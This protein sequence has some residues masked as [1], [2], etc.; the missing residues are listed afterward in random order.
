MM[1]A[2]LSRRAWLSGLSAAAVSHAVP[3]T[4]LSFCSDAPGTPAGN[5][6]F[7]TPLGDISPRVLWGASIGSPA[8][9]DPALVQAL[10]MEKPRV[11]AIANALKFGGPPPGAP[12]PADRWRECD[13]IVSLAMRIG[14]GIRGDALAW[15][16]WLPEWVKTLA[17]QRPTGWRDT[18]RDAFDTHFK[19]VFAHF[20]DLR[21]TL[22][23][24]PL[25]WCGVVNEPFNP[26]AARGGFAGYRDGPWQDAFGTEPDGVPGYIHRAFVLAERHAP[27]GTALFLN[28]TFCDEDRFSVVVRPALLRLVDALQSAGRKVDAVGLECH[29]M[30]QWMR[31]PKN[32]DWK[33]FVG[34]LTELARR[35]VAIYLTE[36]DVND[37]ST[38]DVAERD[39]LVE[40]CTRTFVTAALE[41]PAVTMVTNW[42]LSDK[43]AWLREDTT[44]GGVYPSLGK[45][46]DCVSLPPCPR[47]DLYDQSM[48]PKI[49]RDGLAQALR[50]RA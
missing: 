17:R 16:D 9:E 39:A 21:H 27:P 23:V 10:S 22:G 40:R 13:D 38:R 36:L 3:A 49:V 37:C 33:P 1:S 11:V 5:G 2:P 41:I 42:D 26:W 32:P 25:R 7:G 20:D 44:S 50:T 35:G 15:N 34:F 12:A 30:P 6:T 19:A 47:P 18:L 8:L 24:Q 46:A 28:E 45:W 43:Y 29:L 14:A 4:A 48:R 31:D